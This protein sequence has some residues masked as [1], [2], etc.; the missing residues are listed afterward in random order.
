MHKSL[1]GIS[2]SAELLEAGHWVRKSGIA[3]RYSAQVAP[4]TVFPSC[5]GNGAGRT[6]GVSPTSPNY[7]SPPLSR[8][9]PEP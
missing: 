9:E 1:W 7:T 8:P 4:E 2:G 3:G 5:R 6:A